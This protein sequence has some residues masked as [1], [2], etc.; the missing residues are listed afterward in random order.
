ME[1]DEILTMCNLEKKVYLQTLQKQTKQLLAILDPL[2]HFDFLFRS[3][4]LRYI[5]S[6]VSIISFKSSFFV[7]IELPYPLEYNHGVVFFNMTVWVR[8]NSKNTSKR[9]LF[10]PY[11]SD[12]WQFESH[13]LTCW[14]N[15][16]Y[17]LSLV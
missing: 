1:L 15:R 13:G 2:W 6:M 8:F 12:F 16:L 7:V 14:F 17:R 10:L 9:G 3:S 11:L 4:F 5:V